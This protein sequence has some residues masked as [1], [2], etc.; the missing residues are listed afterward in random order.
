MK[1]FF[2]PFNTI[3]CRISNKDSVLLLLHLLTSICIPALLFGKESAIDGDVK[4]LKRLT[5][6][7]SRAWFKIFT[8]F[9]RHIIYNCQY[10]TDCLPLEYPIDLRKILFYKSIYEYPDFDLANLFSINEHGL[11]VT[12]VYF[13]N[14]R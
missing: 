14:M 10:Y 11:V 8:T 4:E 6:S 3:Y 9:D 2:T 13:Q 7:F 12:S 5:Y 1:K